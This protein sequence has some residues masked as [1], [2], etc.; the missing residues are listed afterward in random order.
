VCVRQGSRPAK[1]NFWKKKTLV[2]KAISFINPRATTQLTVPVMM[3]RWRSLRC[4]G[5]R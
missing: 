3:A 5:L 1:S 4:G 2:K